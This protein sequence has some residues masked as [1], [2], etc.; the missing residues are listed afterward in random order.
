MSQQLF[1]FQAT[2]HEARK[3]NSL[4]R[5]A[6]KQREGAQDKLNAYTGTLFKRYGHEDPES[7]QIAIITDLVVVSDYP[8]IDEILAAHLVV[9]PAPEPHQ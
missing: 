2:P 3:L 8:T 1:S 4:L 5:Q 6:S 9:H 7:Y